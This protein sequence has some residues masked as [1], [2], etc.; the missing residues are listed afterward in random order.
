MARKNPAC[1]AYQKGY[2]S[3]WGY[4][5]ESR[6]VRQG[7][8]IEAAGEENDPDEKAPVTEGASRSHCYHE[9]SDP[10]YEVIEGRCFP[11]S[12]P[13]ILCQQILQCVRSESTQCDT[14]KDDDGCDTDSGDSAHNGDGYETRFRFD[15]QALRGAWFRRKQKTRP[16]FPAG[17]Y[18]IVRTLAL[19]RPWNFVG[20]L[21]Y[22]RKLRAHQ[23]LF[24]FSPEMR[25]ELF[26]PS[27]W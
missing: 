16:C 12:F 17:F 14:E 9:K 10:V 26:S 1:P 24:I 3:E 5:A 23:L 15:R 11:N 22:S 6:D 21:L 8:S 7:Q 25:N 20:P 2:A 19:G 18:E 27:R 4:D 13:S